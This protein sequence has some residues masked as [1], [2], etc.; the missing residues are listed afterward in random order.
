VGISLLLLSFPPFRWGFLIWIAWI[1]L[2]R[3]AY[4]S[5]TP[6]NGFILWGFAG[7]VLFTIHLSWI[8]HLQVEPW[9]EKFLVLGW[10]V[11]VL[12]EALYW[13]LLGWIAVALARRRWGLA[14]P[15]VWL[16][17]EWVRGTGATGFPWAT[18]GLPVVDLP[19][20]REWFAVVGMYGVGVLVLGFS[21]LCVERWS[22]PWAGVL[23]AFLLLGGWSRVGT[24]DIRPKGT[25]RIAILQPNV[26]P[27][28]TYW[29]DWQITR[30]GYNPLLDTLSRVKDSVDLAVLSES[31]FPSFYRFSKIQQAYVQEIFRRTTIRALLFG[32]GDTRTFGGEERPTNTAFL[33]RGDRVLDTYDKVHL[34]PFG[35]WIPW[36][37]RIAWLRRVNFGQGDYVPGETLSPLKLDS[38]RVGVL[39]CFESMFPELARGLARQGADFLA[40]LTNDGWFGKSL[41]P[42]EHFEFARMRALETGREVVR[43]AKT[44]AS[45]I[46]DRYGQVRKHL[47]FGTRG[48]IVGDVNLYEGTTLYVKFGN[49]LAF[50]LGLMIIGLRFF[51][52]R[53]RP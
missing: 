12:Y 43:A 47:P 13:A 26:L 28:T 45:A 7:V 10:I 8:L 3:I 38:V 17:L 46:I 52:E 35:E 2:L 6:W 9:V 18:I 41:G 29:K 30:S 16:I 44:G 33:V 40:N 22:W 36:E 34:V 50:L 24:R 32:S 31:A 39:I 51:Q 49:F 14:I 25:L 5:E 23:M 15:L 48:V 53:R 27:A 11:L 1:P 19:W 37:N 21:V 4:I 42:L 20:L